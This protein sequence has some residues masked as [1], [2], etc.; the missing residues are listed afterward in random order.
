MF[1]LL[2]QGVKT[3]RKYILTDPA[4]HS[5]ERLFGPTDLGVVGMEMVLGNHTCN[6]LCRELGLNN[7]MTGVYINSGPRST[8]YSF[9]VTEQEMLRADRGRSDFFPIL[10]AIYE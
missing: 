3:G 6:V 7:P 10:N 2:L 9:Q 4:I 5:S 8:T 1:C